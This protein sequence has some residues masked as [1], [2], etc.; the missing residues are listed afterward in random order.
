MTN[1]N[2]DDTVRASSDLFSALKIVFYLGPIA[3]FLPIPFTG[4]IWFGIFSVMFVLYLFYK[5]IF[6]CSLL[7]MHNKMLHLNKI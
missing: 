6:V 1:N 7:I 5:Q 4:V 2:S 3:I